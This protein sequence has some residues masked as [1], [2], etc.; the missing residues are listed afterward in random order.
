[1]QQCD[2]RRVR[3]IA[4]PKGSTKNRNR[5][6][7]CAFFCA[8]RTFTPEW[9]MATVFRNMVEGVLGGVLW[10]A[11]C[12]GTPKAGLRRRRLRPAQS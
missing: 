8:E 2:S 9:S 12:G 1:M 3:R 6:K 7:K 10:G 11:A 4:C 5:N